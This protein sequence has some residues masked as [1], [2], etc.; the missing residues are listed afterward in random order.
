MVLI[1]SSVWI[2]F[3]AGHEADVAPVNALL[4]GSNRVVTC[5]VILQEVVQGVREP[6]RRTE[7]AERLSMLPFIEAGKRDHLDA[8]ELYADLRKKGV[9]VPPAD[10]LIATLAINNRHVLLTRDKHFAAISE[11]TDLRQN[12]P[13][14]LNGST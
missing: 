6:R 4:S 10:A 9:T 7:V 5:G 1:D 8:A 2:G 14:G 3:L 11:H 12:Q 13:Y